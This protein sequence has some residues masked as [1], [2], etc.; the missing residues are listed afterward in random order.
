MGDNNV[1]LFREKFER[2]K[3]NADISR[4]CDPSLI[5]ADN[6]HIFNSDQLEDHHALIPLAVLPGSADEKERTIYSIVLSSFFTV[7]MPDFVYK[8]KSL[9]FHI[10]PYV[11]TSSIREVIQAGWKEAFQNDGSDDSEQEATA[12][13]GQN[14]SIAGFKILE[15]KTAPK[16]EFAIDTLLAFMEYPRGE[17]NEK[18]SGLGTPATRAEIIKTLFSRE[19]LIEEKKKLYAT[20]RGRFLLEQLSRNAELGKMADAAQ[21]TEWEQ[22]LGSDPQAFEQEIADYIGRC[23]KADNTAGRP[24]FQ[25]TELGKCPLC[26]R[27]VFETKMG[28]A[29]SGCKSDPQCRFVILKTIAGASVSPTDASLLLI[30]QKTK[31]KKCTSKKG[32]HFETSFTLQGGKIVFLF[33]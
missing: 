23:V 24:A 25:K 7:C 20:R 32:Q 14:C 16:K 31:V 11:F 3:D 13:D 6:R 4:F 15:K 19:Y 1:E 26:K 29:C 22:R 30:G 18:L 10:G 27:P 28:Y 21:T 12:F 9:R 8:E 17:S 33:K 5:S 2:L